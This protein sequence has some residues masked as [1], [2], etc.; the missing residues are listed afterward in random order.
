MASFKEI[1][2]IENEVEGRLLGAALEREGITHTIQ[3]FHDSVYNGI[4]QLQRGWGAVIGPEEEQ[5][6]ILAIL[7]EL[8]GGSAP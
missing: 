7:A 2:R 8:R 5:E 1:A 3:S 4:F 6:R